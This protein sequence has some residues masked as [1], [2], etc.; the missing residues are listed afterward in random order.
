M[1]FSFKSKLVPVPMAFV[2]SVVVVVPLAPLNSAAFNG[3]SSL[4]LPSASFCC[5]SCCSRRFRVAALM[6]V[7]FMERFTFFAGIISVMCNFRFAI[8]NSRKRASFI[9]ERFSTF[10]RKLFAFNSNLLSAVCLSLPI[11]WPLSRGL[12]DDIKRRSIEHRVHRLDVIKMGPLGDVLISFG[13]F[14]SAQCSANFDDKS[15]MTR[16]TVAVHSILGSGI[17]RFLLF[18][19]VTV[20]VCAALN[21]KNHIAF[22]ILTL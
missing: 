22:F 19:S 4:G 9:S 16:I 11:S 21:F 12:L 8:F 10:S 1:G 2:S 3:N 17:C 7:T 14:S 20:V 15:F 5:S 13:C 6:R 18:C